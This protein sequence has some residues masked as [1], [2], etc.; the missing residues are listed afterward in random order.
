MGFENG[1]GGL[2]YILKTLIKPGP[3]FLHVRL[4]KMW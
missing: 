3:L 2:M 1:K 4:Q